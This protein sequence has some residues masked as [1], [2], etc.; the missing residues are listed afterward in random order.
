[1]KISTRGRY[2]L[3]MMV[4]LAEFGAGGRYVT[5]K[6]ISLREGISL[7]YLEQI[8]T[9][10]GKAGLIRSLRG[11]AGGYMLAKDAAEYTA[12]TVIRAAEGDL[13]PVGCLADEVNECS[14]AGYCPTVDFWAGLYKT[15][16]EYVDSVTL[17][18]LAD[19]RRAKRPP[20][21]VI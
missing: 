16:N 21:Y 4:D 10:L 14:R 5:L 6:D 13:A 20:D 2:A 12:G 1:M 15:I 18:D 9:I 11:P 7:K 3:R 19:I 8:V 17:A